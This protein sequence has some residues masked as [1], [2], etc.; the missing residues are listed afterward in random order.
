[1]K[2]KHS[3]S[4]RGRILQYVALGLIVVC[5]V[6]AGFLLLDAWEKSQG[7]FDGGEQSTLQEVLEYNGIEYVI[8]DGLETM[9]FLGL[10]SYEDEA[11]DS[12][13]NNKQ[14]D[15]LLLLVIDNENSSYTALQIN[16][17]TMT[18]MSV[19]DLAGKSIYTVTGQIALAHT[20]GNGKEVSC[21]NVAD[22][23][24]D[25]LLHVGVD[26]YV[27]ATM[28]AVPVYNDY[29][30]GVEV[31]VL[32]D[33]TGI[34]DS[35]VK[36]ETVL[37]TG[38]Q[39]LRYVRS[40]QGLEDSTN[41]HRMER[42][43]QYIKALYEKSKAVSSEKTDFVVG[44]SASVANYIVTD[45]NSNRLEALMEKVLTYKYNGILELEGSSIAGDRFMEFYPTEDSILKV[46]TS[47]FYTPKS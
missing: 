9:L 14:A 4:L 10:D 27:S 21:R 11:L 12:Y 41:L 23:V 45:C 8:R 30:G 33:F 1:M 36:G 29:I 18:E 47:L 13:N 26:H 42:Q 17:D 15:F 2:R 25:L 7:Q 3:G 31:E 34:D 19:L 46:V 37:L 6:S 24:S 44:A 35:L 32:D 38:E 20:Y 43:R 5:V 28:E 39:A 16:R 40:R 22:A